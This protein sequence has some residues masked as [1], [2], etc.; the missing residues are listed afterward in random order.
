[1]PLSDQKLPQ[2]TLPIRPDEE[3]RTYVPGGKNEEAEKYDAYLSTMSDE[4]Y[5]ARL[6]AILMSEEEYFCKS[7]DLFIVLLKWSKR[8]Y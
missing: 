5:A 7:E 1:M 3:D 6:E 4:E 8:C 2:Q